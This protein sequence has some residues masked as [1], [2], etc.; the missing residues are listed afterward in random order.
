MYWEDRSEKASVLGGRD[1][2][3]I[4]AKRKEGEMYSCLRGL[5]DYWKMNV[6]ICSFEANKMGAA[7]YLF[8]S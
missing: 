4:S 1:I 3:V 5:V 2:E 8:S 6:S 7:K